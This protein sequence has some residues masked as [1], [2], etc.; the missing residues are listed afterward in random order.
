MGGYCYLLF[1]RVLCSTA[2]LTCV[3]SW[4]IQWMILESSL[5]YFG[6]PVVCSSPVN[7]FARC[8]SDHEPAKTTTATLSS[9]LFELEVNPW[10]QP[11]V[12]QLCSDDPWIFTLSEWRDI[13]TFLA[14]STF[15]NYVRILLHC[16][17]TFS[18]QLLKYF[19]CLWGC[20]HCRSLTFSYFAFKWF[21]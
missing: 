21:N 15:K 5:L 18:V 8:R 20:F 4:L 7:H 13:V 9:S 14:H 10:L 3:A 6:R 19:S 12:I 17:P 11:F 16:I 2:F 1:S